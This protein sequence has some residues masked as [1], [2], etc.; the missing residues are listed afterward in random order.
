MTEPRRGD[1][2]PAN[3]ALGWNYWSR[4]FRCRARRQQGFLFIT[5]P[6]SPA[7]VRARAI[8]DMGYGATATAEPVFWSRVSIFA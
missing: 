2:T 7:A 3:A 6:P 4:G 1:A 5:E 8:S